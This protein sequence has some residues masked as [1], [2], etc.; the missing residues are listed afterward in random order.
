MDRRNASQADRDLQKSTRNVPPE[1]FKSLPPGKDAVE[2]ISDYLKG[3]YN[4]VLARLTQSYGKEFVD[5]TPIEFVLTV[6]AI[7]TDKARSL[8]KEAA[9]RAGFGS[10]P[11]DKIGMVSEPEA[12]AIYTIKSTFDSSKGTI[13][14]LQV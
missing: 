14:K 13:Q 9:T 6:P 1:G 2:V 7:W 12:A 10:R 11:K 8:T 4:H 3:L 5:L